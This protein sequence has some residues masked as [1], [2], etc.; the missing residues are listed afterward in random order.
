MSD[1]LAAWRL[2][3]EPYYQ[4]QGDECDRFEAAWSRRLPLLLKGPTGC[5]KTRFIEHMAWRMGRPLVTVA[6]NEDTTAGDLLGRW[7][8]EDGATRW[9]DG[10]LALAAR[11]GGICYLDEIVEAR[12][13]TVVAIHPLTDTRR[14]LPLDRASEVIRAH[15]DFMLVVSYNPGG[16]RE[17]KPSTRQRFCGMRFGYPDAE[18][19]AEIL[20]RE[21]GVD[22]EM[23]SALVAL[24]RR[25]RRLAGHGLEE[26]ASTRMLV[27][28]A[29]L[30][31][32]GMSARDA[33]IAALVVPLTDEAALCD[34][35][36]AAV[37][38]SF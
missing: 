11:H 22:V 2:G 6:C 9:Q 4:P 7:L 32:Q 1:P 26:G 25:T 30:L 19:E 18:D 27:R 36:M 12:P 37:D 8:L 31:R 29:Q 34:A 28:A 15:P 20:M 21:G 16:S 14:M 17:L 38:A 10:P 5:G 23:A 24:G 33:C 13:D 3:S 35:L